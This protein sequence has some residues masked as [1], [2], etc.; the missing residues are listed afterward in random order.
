[1]HR[2]LTIDWDSFAQSIATDRHGFQP[3]KTSARL[4]RLWRFSRFTRA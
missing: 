1:M 2:S 4:D 3:H